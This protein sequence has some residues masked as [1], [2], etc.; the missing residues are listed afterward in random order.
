[1]LGARIRGETWY[2]IKVDGVSKGVVL[3]PEGNGKTLRPKIVT[4]FVQDNSKDNIDCTARKAVWISRPSDKVN[5]SMVVWL[6]KREAASYLL[7]KLTVM[8]GP[9]AGFA[10]PY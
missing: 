7:R 10:A 2:P 1:M 8:F 4:N 6:Q 9:T 5:G 3:D